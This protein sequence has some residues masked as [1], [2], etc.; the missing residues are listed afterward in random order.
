MAIIELFSFS[1]IQSFVFQFHLRKIIEPFDHKN[2]FFQMTLFSL[3]PV[4]LD[5][6]VISVV[7]S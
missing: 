3:V 1:F 5:G 6:L 7:Q 4:K 2:F